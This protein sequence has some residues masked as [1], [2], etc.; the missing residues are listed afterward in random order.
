[1]IER[2]FPCAEVSANS[3]SGWG[4]GNSER[5]LFTW[6]AARPTAQAK[7]AV[8][9]SLLPWP[10]DELEQKRLQDLVST[11]MTGRYAE[12]EEL[13]QKIIE[14]H[15]DG[16][17]ILDPFSG[18]GM[19]PLEAAR[20]GIESHGHDYSPVAVLASNLLTSFPFT[21]WSHEPD[22]P[23]GSA[24]S[25]FGSSS[26]KLLSD[27]ASVLEEV[28]DRHARTMAEFY[29]RNEAGDLPWGYLWSISIPCQECGV[30]FPLVGAYELNR[31]R[32]KV[33]AQ[34]FKIEPLEPSGGWR[35][36]VHDGPPQELPTL[37]NAI[38]E[39]GK[40]AKGKS[41]VCPC[42]LHVHT[43]ETHRRL[44]HEGH[45]KD[46]LLLVADIDGKSKK[47]FRVPTDAEC[48]AADQAEVALASEKAFGHLMPAV[49][50]EGIRPG[51]NNIIG[52]S[53][54]GT[55]TFGQFMVARQTLSYVRLAR[56]ISDLG[57]ELMRGGFSHDYARAL[58]GYATGVVVKKLRRSTR[59]ARMQ[60]TG[61]TRVG[62]LFVNEGS[63]TFSHD[64]FEAG[65]GTGPGTWSSIAD[66]VL[67]VM[68]SL[69]GDARGKATSVMHSSATSI[70]LSAAKVAAVVTDPPYDA[71]IAYADASDLFYVW[72]KRC[73]V[74]TWPELSFTA[75]PY[76]A[77]DKVL[78]IIV[79]RQEGTGKLAVRDH[80]TREHYDENIQKAFAEMRRV[81]RDDGVV[82]IVFGHGNPE[83]WQRLLD[84]I[85]CAD[86]VMTA[87]WPANTEAGGSHGNAHIETTL[88][89]ACRPA[90]TNRRPGRKGAVETEIRTEIK[91]RYP[92]WER[93]GLAP[94]DMLMAA[95]G[96]AM[97]VVGRYSE[98]LDATG[99]PVDIYTFLPLARAAV[100]VAMAVEVDHHPLET[101][102]TRT[103]FALWWV[104]LYG[105]QVQPK[106]EL[107][108]QSL[109]ASLDSSDLR[110]LVP[111]SDKGVRF[112]TSR[113]FTSHI[114]DE[115]SV[116]D[117]AL[118]LAAAS[119][120]GIA[121]MG[122]VLAQSGR[123][124]D[125][126]Y[127]WA[128]VKFL[129]DR[130]P[131]SDPDAIAFTRV[132]RTR[133]G[134]ANAADAVVFVAETKTRK[135]KIDDDQLKL[136]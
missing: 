26:E 79:K 111:D 58:C 18:R 112:T 98:V 53:I 44:V 87:S 63:I 70:P 77:Q 15:P 130:L 37:R 39:G 7:A 47:N 110:D 103:R 11:A 84:A 126:A 78:E 135:Q 121:A 69:L 50:D 33:E 83:V 16:A 36:V 91:R 92:D 88:T 65:I 48:R 42:C 60:T 96:P 107:R 10:D 8:L 54:Y 9:C 17:S 86:L 29:P 100:Q 20:L 21:D 115:S 13:R 25:L 23:F 45:G 108:W 82:T 34:S 2:W 125:D 4:S 120:E 30:R 67:S 128:A 99:E 75:D 71:M 129:A 101:F 94:A 56:I 38:L 93:W 41:A 61:G 72:I 127:L 14:G 27:V 32:G 43:L 64:F 97:E 35:V 113:A 55:K 90:P 24:D 40:K 131:D 102:D 105:R 80:R 22:L 122:E 76:G 117:V 31:A 46:L 62:D 49:P 12:W 52:P 119:E 109:A 59:G 51:N 85:S 1:M 5:N 28:G 89:M 6:F 133:D 106:S 116:I 57:D 95:A 132:M 104:R 81:V 118:A 68:R 114:T 74:S 136:L 19:I 73:M 123:G 66:N 3:S 124:A 134:I